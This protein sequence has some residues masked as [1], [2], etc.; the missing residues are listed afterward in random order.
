MIRA[1]K[2]PEQMT[3]NQVV[4]FVRDLIER[5]EVG[6][7]ARLPSERE[8]AAR[9]GVSRPSVRAGLQAL[10]A[11]GVIH[12]RHGAGTFIADGPP[13]LATGPLSFLVALHKFSAEEMFE[14]RRVL[15]IAATGLAAER[16]TGENLAAI[17]EEMASMFASLGDPQTFLVHDIRFHRA[18][19]TASQNP[20]LASLVEMISA[21]FYERRRR[22]VGRERDLKQAAEMHRTI[23]NWLRARNP[24]AA[25]AAM[26]EHLAQSQAL[27]TEGIDR[28]PVSVVTP[29]DAAADAANASPG[30]SADEPES[31]PKR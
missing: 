15:E 13:V 19:A 25:R 21:M 1:P 16:A 28:F 26:G 17:A 6:P 11:M 22:N 24:E 30:G 4:G 29:F 20:I 18:L 5:G 23:Y 8:L 3:V 7:G 9:I 31:T 27:S 14:A 2:S 10:A 12:T